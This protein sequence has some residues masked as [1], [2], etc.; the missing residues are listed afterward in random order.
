MKHATFEI[1]SYKE[2]D[3]VPRLRGLVRQPD[4]FEGLGVLPE[5]LRRG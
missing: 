5:V 1:T 4:G 3:G 2:S